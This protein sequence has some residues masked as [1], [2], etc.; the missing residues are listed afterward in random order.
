[1][2]WRQ[3]VLVSQN[4]K[5]NMVVLP[6]FRDLPWKEITKQK[7]RSLTSLL[8]RKQEKMVIKQKGPPTTCKR[9]A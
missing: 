5:Q 2:A 3:W 6:T 8:N 9:S 7:N 1:M 4:N